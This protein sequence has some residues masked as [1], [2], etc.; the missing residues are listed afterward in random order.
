M[1]KSERQEVAAT[2]LTWAEYYAGE[3][4]GLIYVPENREVWMAARSMATAW[5]VYM[6]PRGYHLCLIRNE[7]VL[8]LCFAAAMVEAGDST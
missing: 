8:G 1:T 5:T 6:S 3:R 4:S 7:L 2:L